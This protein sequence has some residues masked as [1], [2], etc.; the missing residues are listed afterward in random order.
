MFG[1][2]SFLLV[3]S[4]YL[5]A[6]ALLSVASE[7]ANAQTCSLKRVTSLEMTRSP[8]GG[9]TVPVTINGMQRAFL[10]SVGDT[11]S[12]IVKD[13]AIAMDL[14][15]EPLDSVQEYGASGLRM[16]HYVMASTFVVGGVPVTH[17]RLVASTR[18]A[19]SADVSGYLGNDFLKNFDVDLDFAVMK[20]NL[21][22]PDHCAGKVVYWAGDYV[23]LPFK[24]SFGNR[25]QVSVTL[26]G[27][28][29]TAVLD[30]TSDRSYIDSSIAGRQYGI[31][32]HSPG[33]VPLIGTSEIRQAPFGYRFKSLSLSG[34]S[35]TNPLIGL[36][37]NQAEAAFER[38]E[39]KVAS[40]IPG[41]RLGIVP[42]EIGLNV[43]SKL[44][45]YIAY[46]EQ[47]IYLT[48]ADAGAA[49]AQSAP[50]AEKSSAQ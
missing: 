13:A 37:H 12:R 42:L 23:E 7:S 36:L 21:F 38:D 18:N 31:D 4:R 50:T 44:H 5:L 1:S 29:L 34:I 14:R 33:V 15:L 32:D 25:I 49:P 48:A 22:S 20:L 17:A 16:D 27:H 19:E 8:G 35:D 3:S 2:R 9:V 45:L 30:P 39:G 26:D 40:A 24:V 46:G 11:F 6:A 47:K 43:L 28:D 41:E 10:V